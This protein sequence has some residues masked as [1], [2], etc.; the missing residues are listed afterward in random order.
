MNQKQTYTLTIRAEN[1]E[2]IPE[3]IRLRQIVKSLLRCYSFKVI[4]LVPVTD[5]TT[6]RGE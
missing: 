1:G 3:I 2:R 4:R 6:E 5:E